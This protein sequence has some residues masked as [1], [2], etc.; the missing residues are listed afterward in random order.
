VKEFPGRS[1][2]SCQTKYY[3]IARDVRHALDNSVTENRSLGKPTDEAPA[4]SPLAGSSSPNE[5]RL[6]VPGEVWSARDHKKLLEYAKEANPDWDA[7]AKYFPGRTGGG[8][9]ARYGIFRRNQRR[10][11]NSAGSESTTGQLSVETTTA[12][13]ESGSTAVALLPRKRRAHW[14]GEELQRIVQ[15]QLRYGTD[16]KKISAQFP[17]RT[18]ASCKRRFTA[19]QKSTSRAITVSHILPPLPNCPENAKVVHAHILLRTRSILKRRLFDALSSRARYP[20]SKVPVRS[21]EAAM[22]QQQIET[23]PCFVTFEDFVSF[24]EYIHREYAYRHIIDKKTEYIY[25]HSFDDVLSA[26]NVAMEDRIRM[27]ITLHK[28]TNSNPEFISAIGSILSHE[29]G[30]D[31]YESR[32][33][34]LFGPVNST[35][36]E[37]ATVCA[38][39]PS[40]EWYDDDFTEDY[41]LEFS[42]T[43]RLCPHSQDNTTTLEGV[44]NIGNSIFFRWSPTR[45][46]RGS[47][48]VGKLSIGF[49]RLI[50]RGC[51][52]M[53]LYDS[54]REHPRSTAVLSLPRSGS[55]PNA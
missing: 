51:G 48:V 52:A 25:M 1:P 6:S 10:E 46:I 22:M 35:D 26:L 54:F 37:H 12:L 16:W 39:M 47:Q 49:N 45:D 30:I 31:G 33:L 17:G 27:R 2:H 20:R 13:V 29:A 34:H 24:K 40:I 41:R 8:C 11:S 9:K 38:H 18:M 3:K 44:D 7:I 55:Q 23:I 4:S 50:L 43:T 15:T 21:V 42:S 53:N 28:S 14:S 36:D 32:C 5:L 19:L